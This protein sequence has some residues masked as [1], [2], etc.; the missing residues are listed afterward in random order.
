MWK[1][2]ERKKRKRKKSDS[3]SDQSDGHQTEPSINL[4]SSVLGAYGEVMYGKPVGP[5][6]V[7]V[8]EDSEVDVNDDENDA[9]EVDNG[10]RDL[11]MT[12]STPAP[13]PKLNTNEFRC[14]YDGDKHNTRQYY[15]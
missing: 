2:S 4:T 12:T 7:F 15:A 5:T 9:D 14:L 1:R 3:V 13:I 6:Q 8:D 10:D 11:K